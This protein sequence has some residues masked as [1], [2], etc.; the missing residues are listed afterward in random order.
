MSSRRHF[1]P[2]PATVGKSLPGDTL[3]AEEAGLS[4]AS[5]S[6]RVRFSANRLQRKTEN[7]IADAGMREYKYRTHLLLHVHASSTRIFYRNPHRFEVCR[8]SSHRIRTPGCDMLSD[9]H[10]L[11]SKQQWSAFTSNS[12][13]GTSRGDRAG[14]QSIRAVGKGERGRA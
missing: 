3:E 6:P 14:V 9:Q 10:Q 2:Q 1:I 13:L 4:E 11:K 5:A 8:S 7:I 12:P